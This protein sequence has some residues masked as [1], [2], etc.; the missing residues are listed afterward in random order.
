VMDSKTALITGGS[1]GLG[2]ELARQ[3]AARG[4]QLLLVARDPKRLERAAASLRQDFKVDVAIF[5]QDL[6]LRGAAEAVVAE[7]RLRGLLVDVLINNAGFAYNGRFADQDFKELESL[8]QTNITAL[9]MLTRLLLPDMLARRSGHILNVASTAAF[10][11]GPL[12]AT[13]YASKAYVLSFTEALALE[14]KGS[15]V[16]ATVVCPGVMLTGFQARAGLRENAGMLRT[17]MRMPATR[18]ARIAYENMLAGKT[19][20]VP[21]T[22]NAMGAFASVHVP[23][24][25]SAP[26]VRSMHGS[27]QAG[28]RPS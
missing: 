18:A 5:P 6:G 11:P 21:G 19:V 24:A 1:S 9:T 25:L 12:M 20:S 28:E 4:C 16:S 26:V 15:G 14:L 13:Y 22:L 3:A 23:H 10:L 17:P 7:V 2:Y 8:L 27:P